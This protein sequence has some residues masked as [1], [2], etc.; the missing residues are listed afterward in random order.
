MKDELFQIETN[1]PLTV[2]LCCVC[3]CVWGGA[4]QE[5]KDE[6]CGWEIVVCYG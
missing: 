4:F 3:V 1:Y 6:S 5:K 2:S